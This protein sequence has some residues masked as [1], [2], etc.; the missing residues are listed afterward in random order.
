ME[1]HAGLAR[2]IFGR[3]RSALK[4]LFD[5]D[6][7]RGDDPF[8]AF[9]VPV[10]KLEPCRKDDLTSQ[11]TL[12]GPGFACAFSGSPTSTPTS[13]LTTIIAIALTMRSGSRA[14]RL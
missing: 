11:L 14:P 8:I 6:G 12:A 4:R 3:R 1:R 9:R 10:T 2:S 5:R 13:I 7:E